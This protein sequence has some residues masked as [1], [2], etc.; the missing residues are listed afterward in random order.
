MKQLLLN[1]K[2]WLILGLVF[3]VMAPALGHLAHA[4]ILNWDPDNER[5]VRMIFHGGSAVFII[6]GIVLLSVKKR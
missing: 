6:I 2:F 5:P 1:A 4:G 3:L